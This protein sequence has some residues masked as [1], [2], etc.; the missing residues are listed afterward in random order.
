MSDLEQFRLE[1]RAW[2]EENCPESMRRPRRNF[3]DMYSGGRNPEMAHPDEKVWC[4]RMAEK[5]WTVP[6][7]P[8]E[9]GGGG[10]EKDEVK[11]LRQE[12]ARINARSPLDS[13]GISM[14]GPALLKFGNEEQKPRVPHHS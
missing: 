11:V 4:D 8:R 5:G 7:W 9:Y 10:L 2:L 14:L 13:F 1:T 12:M 6:H 3:E